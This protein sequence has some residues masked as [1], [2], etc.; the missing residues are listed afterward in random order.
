MATKRAPFLTK[1][2]SG[3]HHR[4]VTEDDKELTR[5]MITE[6]LGKKPELAPLQKKMLDDRND[7]MV[8]KCEEYLKTKDVYF[9]VAGAAHMIGDKGICE[10]LRK[11]GYKVEQVERG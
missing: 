8:K 5:M 1:P 10:L 7:G 11:K 6:G 9:V 2:Y 4:E 3:Y